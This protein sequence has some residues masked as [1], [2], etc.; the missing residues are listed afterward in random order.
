MKLSN[1][2]ANL[3]LSKKLFKYLNWKDCLWCYARTNLNEK[4]KLIL[5][6]HITEE[7][8]D[9][10]PAYTTAELGE[11]LPDRIKIKTHTMGYEGDVIIM[12][13][14]FGIKGKYNKYW[15]A[16]G[17]KGIITDKNYFEAN[18]EANARAKMLVYLLENN[19][20]NN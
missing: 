19:L 11:M 17:E 18:T 14:N 2:V 7:Y 12:E 10:I 16:Y 15:L 20:T 8:D 9:T 3:E 4:Y 6:S 13:L 1:Q 5:S